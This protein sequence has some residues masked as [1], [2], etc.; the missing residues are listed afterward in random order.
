MDDYWIYIQTNVFSITQQRVRMDYVWRVQ[1][2]YKC[3][4]LLLDVKHQGLSIGNKFL[5]SFIMELRNN[6]RYIFD[7]YIQY[8]DFLY[9]QTY[10]R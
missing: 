9:Y 3:I 2:H 7:T 4:L 1:S 6:L 8:F 5:D 10:K